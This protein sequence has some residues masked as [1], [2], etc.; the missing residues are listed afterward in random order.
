MTTQSLYDDTVTYQEMFDTTTD[1]PM[2]SKDIDAAALTDLLAEVV[3]EFIPDTGL[4]PDNE[5]VIEE[6]E[7]FEEFLEDEKE[8]VIFAITYE[9]T[10]Q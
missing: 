2:A 5:E 9:R 6:T 10:Q 3:D 7:E 4:E 1:L 8:K